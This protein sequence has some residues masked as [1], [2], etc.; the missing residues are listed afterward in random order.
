MFWPDFEPGT[1]VL[2]VS[3]FYVTLVVSAVPVITYS[4]R[5]CAPIPVVERSKARFC[6][7]SLAGVTS[8]H[9]AGEYGCLSVV[10]VVRC[11]AEVSAS[12]RSFG[13]RRSTDCC[14]FLCVL[15]T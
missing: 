15:E 13:Q 1:S 10:S 14:V 3:L 2:S 6:G 9:P 4:P 12:G 11:Q 7:R 8:S 5:T